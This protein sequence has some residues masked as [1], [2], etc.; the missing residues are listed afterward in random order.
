MEQ[1]IYTNEWEIKGSFEV[2]GIDIAGEITKLAKNNFPEYFDLFPFNPG[3]K[4]DAYSENNLVIIRLEDTT[5]QMP[6][7]GTIEDKDIIALSKEILKENDYPDYDFCKTQLKDKGYSYNIFTYVG[8][9]E[10]KKLSWPHIFQNIKMWLQDCVLPRISKLNEKRVTDAIP[11]PPRYDT[12]KLLDNVYVIESNKY[13]IQGTAFHIKGVGLVSC[14]HCIRDLESGNLIDDLFAFRGNKFDEKYAVTIIASNKDIDIS[15][16]GV[17]DG[18]FSEGL[19]IGNSDNLK[20]LDHIAVAGFPNYNVGDN[21]FFSPGLIIGFRMF[22]GLRHI[23]VNAALV[24]GNSGGPAFDQNSKV[25]G[26]VV[27]GVDKFYKAHDT[28]KHGLIPIEAINFINK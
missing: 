21:G 22:S 10:G 1:V 13:A 26:I 20:Q 25:V 15:I 14:D 28:E 17:E 27:T 8:K 2:A 9:V 18:L 6:H 23:L 11:V 16:L 4:T 5:S 7:A 19:E 3:F 12:K 24:S